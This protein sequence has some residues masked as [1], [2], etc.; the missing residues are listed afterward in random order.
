LVA[1]ALVFCAVRTWLVPALIVRVVQSRLAG[2]ITIRDWWL[3]TTSAGVVGVTLRE[4]RTA[5]SPVWLTAQRVATDLSLRGLLQGRFMP[6]QVTVERPTVLLRLD[7]RGQLLTPLPVRSSGAQS[8]ALPAVTVTRARITVRQEGRDAM[9]V[10]DVDVRL[11]P[12]GSRVRLGVRS[13]D[14]SWGPLEA[15]GE[16]ESSFQ[17]GRLDMATPAGVLITPEKARQIPFVPPEV[18][19]HIVPNGRVDVGLSIRVEAGPSVRV[20]TTVGLRRTTVKSTALDLVASDTVGEVIVDGA[21]VQLS[22]VSGSAFGGRVEADGTLDFSQAPPSF[23]LRL[24]L[25]GIDVTDAPPSWQLRAAEITGKL[26]GSVQL[27]V[28]LNRDGVDLS[29]SSGSA[30]VQD[31]TVQG[32]PIKSL[33]LTMHAHGKDL[34]FDARE[35]FAS[36]SAGLL[37]RLSSAAGPELLGGTLRRFWLPESDWVATNLRAL[38]AAAVRAGKGAA[39]AQ[40]SR[41]NSWDGRAG[42]QL[43]RSVRMHWELEDVD[44]APLIAKVKAR[45]SLPFPV[46]CSGRLSVNARATVPLRQLGDLREYAFHGALTL[47]NA[48]LFGLHVKHLAAEVDLTQG[49]LQLLDFRGILVDHSAAQSAGDSVVGPAR[50]GALPRCGFRGSFRA[51]LAPLGR[52]TARFQA[53]E[54]PAAEL[55][56]PVRGHVGPIGGRLS[57]EGD[58]QANLRNAAKAR[59]WTFSGTLAGTQLTY[60]GAVLDRVALA[61]NGRD[62]R[63]EVTK[64]E[65]RLQDESLA[66]AFNVDLAPPHAFRGSIK[67]H[68]WDLGALGIL[69]PTSLRP[70]GLSGTLTAQAEAE[71]TAV[72]L[73]LTTSGAARLGR[74]Q[75]G[76][77][78]FGDVPF[79]WK[80]DAD[81]LILSGVD[82]HPFGGRLQADARIP[83]TATGTTRGTVSVTTLDTAKLAAAIPGPRLSLEGNASG[84]ATFVIPH[85][86]VRIE[87]AVQLSAPD[88]KVHGVDV[89][90]IAASIRAHQANIAYQLTADG[91]GATVRLKGNVPLSGPSARETTGARLQVTSLT[92]ERVWKALGVT[93][94]ATHLEGVGSIDADLRADRTAT[95]SDFRARGVAEFQNLRWGPRVPLGNIRGT[96]ALTPTT[97]RI[98]PLNGELL[99]GQ[100][101]GFVLGTQ[102]PNGERE[103]GFEF[104]IDNAD[105]KHALAFVP[106]VAANIEGRGAILMTGR[107]DETFHAN[108]EVNVASARFAGFPLR[109]LQLPADISLTPGGGEG[110]VHV[111]RWSARVAGGRVRGTAALRIGT[112]QSFQTEVQLL[113]LD[114]EAVTRLLSDARQ[115]AAGKVSGKITLGGSDP[116]LVQTY[117]GRIALDLDDASL[118]SIPVFRELDKFL[119]ASRGGLFENGELSA[120]IANRQLQIDK[121]ALEGRLAQIHGTG[122][123][124]FGGQLNLEMLVNTN[125]IIAQTGE[126][127]LGIVP[128]LRQVIRRR[129]EA[130]L[131]F[132]SF[133]S[134]RLI[135]LRVTGTLKNPSVSVDPSIR[136]ADPALGFFSNVFEVPLGFAR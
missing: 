8:A 132:S 40:R 57:I 127:L 60:H 1:V 104:R 69:L 90:R 125:E 20:R 18:W 118:V 129:E 92:L 113:D 114:L 103:V 102:L 7:R 49:V 68:D 11:R 111:R 124:G 96:V 73:A 120:V 5:E 37:D 89:E 59:A 91:L 41:N 85:D 4:G 17:T 32:I 43:P 56:A 51:E 122:T 93:G 133:L 77:A 71:G 44:L 86:T 66:G 81:Y 13:S 30:S 25:M 72:P 42:V 126:A 62:G 46:H 136:I 98:D 110:S 128:G 26:S 117:R 19:T 16:F 100:A 74:L 39:V 115:T 75:I 47:R 112:D 38:Q 54:L 76:P 28:L 24:G 131:R 108:A 58:V 121:L 2:T 83:L 48:S 3:N 22:R 109:E 78:P 87:A 33:A 80:T 123:V 88:L 34:Q 70:F 65:A 79:Q 63:L 116:A 82:A 135:K 35:A 9:E 105:L 130:R 14:Q 106:A 107:L 36:Q 119:G 97:W 67:L 84:T 6:G 64:V 95:G 52:F 50:T 45:I 29:G 15:E 94:A 134:N 27:K 61:F 53:N 55:V 101:N 31:A 99:S 23:D 12:E 21:V 10:A